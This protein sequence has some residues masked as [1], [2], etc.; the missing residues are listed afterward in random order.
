MDRWT[1]TFPAGPI[2]KPCSSPRP[3]L[4]APGRHQ[5]KRHVLVGPKGP[6]EYVCQVRSEKWW[7]GDVDT[8]IS[9]CDVIARWGLTEHL[10]TLYDL[11]V[12]YDCCHCWSSLW[13]ID[14]AWDF[15]EMF[16]FQWLIRTLR[17]IR[18]N[19]KNNLIP[20]T[21][22]HLYQMSW[23]NCLD[24]LLVTH[25]IPIVTKWFLRHQTS[26]N[27]FQSASVESKMNIAH[28]TNLSPMI[29]Q[30]S[31]NPKLWCKWCI[32]TAVDCTFSL[33]TWT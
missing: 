6:K 25:V 8:Q 32:P 30:T 14:H 13:S 2:S 23:L 19:W 31:T 18:S 10:A 33:R 1:R 9:W 28:L 16:W 24:F 3:F 12:V 11:L 17:T 29:P 26:W 22:A 20:S 7:S 4:D 5:L 27:K 21:S 15:D